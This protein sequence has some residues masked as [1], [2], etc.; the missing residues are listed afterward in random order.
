METRV[1][2]ILLNYNENYKNII[3]P[4]CFL[5]H[6]STFFYFRPYGRLSKYFKDYFPIELIKT[7]DLNPDGK[8]LLCSHPHGTI[9]AGIN[10]A[11]ATN[12]CGWN[13]KF[14]GK[15]LIL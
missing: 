10:I 13:E 1:S 15:Y 11:T 12:Y 4:C 14:P 2:S 6:I 5:D 3:L 8:Y 7:S 9:P